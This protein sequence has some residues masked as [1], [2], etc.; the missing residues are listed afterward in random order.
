MEDRYGGIFKPQGYL[1]KLRLNLKKCE[2]ATVSEQSA[3]RC[4]V[5]L[6][7]KNSKGY[8]DEGSIHEGVLLDLQ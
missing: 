4:S 8:R 1:L 5:K 6:Q 7:Y 2:T 3:D